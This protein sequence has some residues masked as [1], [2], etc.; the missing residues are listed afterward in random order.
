LQSED[1]PTDHVQAG[2]D[3]VALL[4]DRLAGFKGCI[5]DAFG[6]DFHNPGIKLGTGDTIEFLLQK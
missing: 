5:D 3:F 2:F 4:E 1:H 6:H